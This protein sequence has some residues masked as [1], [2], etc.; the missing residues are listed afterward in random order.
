MGNKIINTNYLQIKHVLYIEIY[1]L[2]WG[3]WKV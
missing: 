2:Y 3:K 1:K